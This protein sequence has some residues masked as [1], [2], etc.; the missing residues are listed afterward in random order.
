MER[1]EF[2]SLAPEYYM[3]AFYIYFENPQNFYTE[4]G[5]IEDFTF[6][7]E[8]HYEYCY[9]ENEALRNE[10]LRLLIKHNAIAIIPDPFGPTLWQ[11]GD[12]YDLLED[13][14]QN[15]PASVFYKARVSGVVDFG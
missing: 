14:L 15:S 7:T 12:G 1:S 2:I 3:Q 5:L 11:K 6:T 13:S 9:V 8:D 4:R 10:A